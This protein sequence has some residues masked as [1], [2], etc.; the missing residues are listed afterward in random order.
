MIRIHQFTFGPFG[1]NT[2]LLSD[3][4][5]NAIVIDPGMSNRTEQDEFDDYLTKNGLTLKRLL[6]THG[7][8]DHVMGNAHILKKYNTSPEGH[9]K[10]NFNIDLAQNAASMYGI[11]YDP[12]PKIT[13]FLSEEDVVDFG[14]EQLEIRF[15][16]GHA[17]GHI[18]FINHSDKWVINGDVLFN[19]GIGRYD[20][21]G[22]NAEDL[23]RSI[24]EKM[25]TLPD[26]Y[27]VHCGHGPSTTIGEEKCENPFVKGDTRLEELF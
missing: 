13:E 18:V 4:D 19:R 10:C 14:G 12:S 6:L 8:I 15:T 1:E 22:C 17:P 21:P 26:D 11:P 5:N 7:H 3:E 23:V 27:T 9:E 16:P 24:L 25:Y 20:L 2:F